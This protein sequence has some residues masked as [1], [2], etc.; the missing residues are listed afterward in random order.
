VSELTT[1]NSCELTNGKELRAWWCLEWEVWG[2]SVPVPRSRRRE[3]LRVGE[4]L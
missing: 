3:F 2:L 4:G 1:D